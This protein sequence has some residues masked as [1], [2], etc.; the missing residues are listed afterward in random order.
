MPEV[1][2]LSRLISA[3]VVNQEFRSLLLSNPARALSTGY[4]GERFQLASQEE[5]LILSIQA[6]TLVE[7]AKQ[8]T[9]TGK[10]GI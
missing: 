9:T 4:N 7:F 2:E 6:S 1:G 3:A 8:I 5:Q 10:R